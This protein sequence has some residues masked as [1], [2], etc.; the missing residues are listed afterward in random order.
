MVSLLFTSGIAFERTFALE[1]EPVLRGLQ[2]P[3]PASAAATSSVTAATSASASTTSP[4]G[5][6]HGPLWKGAVDE[7]NARLK[8]KELVAAEACFRE[9]VRA[10]KRDK[11]ITP[12][13]LVVCLESLAGV[14]QTEDQTQDAVPLYQ[15][16]LRILERAHGKE[17]EKA[18]PTITILGDIFCNEAQYKIAAKYYRQA[19]AIV[20]ETSGRSSFRFADLEHRIGLTTFKAGYPQLAQEM[21][22]ISLATLMR[23][24]KLPN[25]DLLEDLIS[26]YTESLRKT[27]AD[28]RVLASNFQSELLNDRVGELV[29]SK[30]ADDS[31]WTKQVSFD[32][33]GSNPKQNQKS[34]AAVSQEAQSSA[35]MVH[36][37]DGTSAR[38]ASAAMQA[39]SL[40]TELSRR[41]SDSAA[42]QQINKQRVDFY[43]RMIAIDAKTLGPQHPSMAR[44]LTGLAYVY[45]SQKKYQEAKALLTRALAIYQ[46]TYGADPLS[47][48]RTEFLLSLI[49]HKDQADAVSGEPLDNYLAALPRIPI[50]AQKIDLALRLNYLAL[51]CYSLGELEEA[52]RIYSWALV[53][54]A[55]ACGED[56]ML[57]GSCLTDYARVLRSAGNQLEAEKCE[58]TA[59]KIASRAMFREASV[60][61]P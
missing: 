14:L 9:A 19:L 3:V 13:D 42:L 11:A 22:S 6:V 59:K 56:S 31:F 25:G 12:D 1:P 43:E 54:T 26:D 44:D 4:A 61:L 34:V 23:Q 55:Q 24:G 48:K 46:Q 28:R 27:L 57:A 53:S 52:K 40:S 18:V 15:K 8:L 17:S 58:G 2:A 33:L 30:S 38:R 60:A 20:E 37:S 10:A 39:G 7:G 32:L 47:V 21:Y 5:S 29:R 36:P 16:S 49:D 45:L 35:D 51:L 41:I 50:E